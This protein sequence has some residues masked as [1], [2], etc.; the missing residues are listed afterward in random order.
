MIFSKWFRR[1]AGKFY[2]FAKF[3]GE[4][5]MASAVADS[6]KSQVILGANSVLGGTCNIIN[7]SNDQS[8]IVIG[9]NCWIRCELMVYT[10]RGF[11][12]IGDDVFI[13]PGTKIWST[14]KISIGNRVLISHNVNIHDNDSHPLNSFERHEHFKH[15]LK[16]DGSHESFPFSEAEI[17]IE[18][19]VWIGFNATIL[20]GVRIGKGAIIGS[21][22]VITKD[23]PPFAL[24]IN[25]VNPVIVKYSD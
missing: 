17:V 12:T 11:I 20:K 24:I 15:L 14:K 6:R 4:R 1:L 9:S 7:N 18:D 8:K 3:E 23:V 21:N 10:T 22:S 5:L 13:G 19:D 25:Q 2:L 16:K